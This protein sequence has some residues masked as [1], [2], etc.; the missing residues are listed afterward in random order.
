MGARSWLQ[1]VAAAR[2]AGFSAGPNGPFSGREDPQTGMPIIEFTPAITQMLRLDGF[3]WSLGELYRTQPAVRICVRFLASNIAHLKLKSYRRT[4]ETP[5][6]LRDHP[7]PLLLEKPNL[8]TSGF[9]LIYGTVSDMAIYDT[10]Y[11]LKVYSG[12]AK[13]LY[14]IP[15][16]Y[17]A[18][19]GGNILT[20]PAYYVIQVGSGIKNVTPDQVVDFKGYNAIDTRIGSSPLEA[21]RAVLLEEVAASAH[22]AGFWRNAARRDGVIERPAAPAAPA[23]D[24]TARARFREDWQN[25]TAGSQNAGI[26]PI[27]EDG[28]KWNPDSFSPKDSEFI[29]GRE[30]AIDTVATTYSIP[31][32]LLSRKGTSTFASLQE[33]HKMLYVDVLGPWNARIERALWLQLLPDFADPDLYVEFNIEEKLQGDFAEQAAAARN[34]VQVPYESVN[35][36]R[37]KR[38]LPAVGDPTDP[39]NPYNSPAR[40]ANYTYGDQQPAPPA[41]P[42]IPVQQQLPGLVP[43]GMNGH[44]ELTAGDIDDLERVLEEL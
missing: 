18:P 30:F 22:R 7:L 21:L 12:N 26:T 1:H 15:P 11:W 20:G 27:L 19:K 4:A 41:A 29:A 17:V 9:D 23:W 14:R 13:S 33:F 6:L 31:L 10:A 35:G 36:Y 43:G 42:G 8:R 5:D 3:G 40:P 34:S 37:A 2:R 32:A 25:R 24:D 28:M 16:A 38:G 44:R 39:A